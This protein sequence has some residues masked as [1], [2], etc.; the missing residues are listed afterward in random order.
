MYEA[1]IETADEVLV[2]ELIGLKIPG[3]EV[4]THLR[5][6]IQVD[7]DMIQVFTVSFASGTAVQLFAPWLKSKIKRNPDKTKVNGLKAPQCDIEITVIIKGLD[8]DD[9]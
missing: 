8:S 7:W 3:I 5:A 4:S 9:S 6:A 2:D 1:I